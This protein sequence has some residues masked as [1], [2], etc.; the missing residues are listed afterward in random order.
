MKVRANFLH[1]AILSVLAQACA[2]QAQFPIA[3][4]SSPSTSLP[5][6]T[7]T[8]APIQQSDFQEDLSMIRPTRTPSPPTNTP[9]PT[10][11]AIFEW[12]EET[13]AHDPLAR[14]DYVYSV[15]GY[16]EQILYRNG[17]FGHGMDY[18]A[19]FSNRVSFETRLVY[20]QK[21]ID[22]EIESRPLFTPTGKLSGVVQLCL[23]YTEEQDPYDWYYSTVWDRP[24]LVPQKDIFYR[25]LSPAT[26]LSL[27]ALFDRLRT[28]A[29]CL[30]VP[31]NLPHYVHRES[32][33]TRLADFTDPLP[34]CR[35]P[36]WNAFVPGE[37]SPSAIEPFFARLGV[38]ADD[39]ETIPA[40]TP[41]LTLSSALFQ[42]FPYDFPDLPPRLTIV[43]NPA[44][45]ISVELSNIEPA[46]ISVR[47]IVR[48]MGYP[49][50]VYIRVDA[51]VELRY[52]TVILRYPEQ[53]TSIFI[54]GTLV[55]SDET[56][57]ELLCLTDEAGFLS[58][59]LFYE[60]PSDVYQDLSLWWDVP[61]TAE[62][63]RDEFIWTSFPQDPT[64]QTPAFRMDVAELTDLLTTQDGCL[65]PLF[66]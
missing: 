11:T 62:H 64:T 22:I 4:P 52:F 16:P 51:R 45:T 9:S 23:D 3:S 20:P 34:D 26:G 65:P 12:P 44:Q 15:L 39:I 28:P 25:D 30:A 2:A 14:L 47:E 24:S 49:E 40:D 13:E 17:S 37:S 27:T 1:L 66:H 38:S 57:E 43:W 33:A 54:T 58:H 60:Q 32:D 18:G 29:S 53:R 55:W 5:P 8:P 61:V 7:T 50:Q 46:F 63:M 19:D 36:C 10:A 56:G 42:S 31:V 59:A 6:T 21:D 48:A 35:P 41:G